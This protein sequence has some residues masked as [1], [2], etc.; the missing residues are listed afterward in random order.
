MKISELREEAE[1][2]LGKRFDVRAFHD[3]VL[4]S[5][6]VPLGMLEINVREWIERSKSEV[7]G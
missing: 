2:E 3:V 1:S 4:G 5:G 6:A 7:G